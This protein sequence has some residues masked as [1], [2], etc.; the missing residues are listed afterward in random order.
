MFNRRRFLQVTSLGS[1]SLFFK[2]SLAEQVS[3]NNPI[4][5]STW[6]P[7]IKANEVAWNILKNGGLSLDAVE[8]GVQVAEADPN[9]QSVGYGGL[10][11]RE[12]KVTLDACIMDE[13][14]NCGSV[15]FLEGIKHPIKL[16]RLVMEK[17][18][19]VILVGEG[20][21]Q[22]ALQNG[23]TTENLLTEKSEQDWKKWLK[24]SKY[25]PMIIPDRLK[26][27]KGQVDNHDTIGMLAL[28]SQGKVAGACTTSGMA[29]KMRGRVGDSPVI[30]A[31]LFVDAEIGAATAT[32]VGEEVIRICGSHTV[33]EYMRQGL[34]PETACKKTVE[35]LVRLR[36]SKAND[37]QIGFIALNNKGEFGGYSLRNGFTYAVHNR[38]GSRIFHAKSIL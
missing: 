27:Q 18:P 21:L 31:G 28:D 8:E 6:E 16:A 36:G 10:P 34:N 37:L 32:G 13:K 4:V 1:L 25:D 7:N 35:R 9:D 12:G 26:K 2:Q 14:G 20:A 38:K 30:G 19:H 29:F 23:F 24:E 11:D 22:F 33:V 3:K 17:T 5:I 15:M